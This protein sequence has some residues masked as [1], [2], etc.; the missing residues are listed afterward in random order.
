MSQPLTLP[1]TLPS[2]TTEQRFPNLPNIRE[3]HSLLVTLT[4]EHRFVLGDKNLIR[5]MEKRN[6]G[7]PARVASMNSGTGQSSVSTEP[8]Y[9]P[10]IR[11]VVSSIETVTMTSDGLQRKLLASELRD[12]SFAPLS[13]TPSLFLDERFD[14]SNP[15]YYPNIPHS[16]SELEQPSTDPRHRYQ[17]YNKIQRKESTEALRKE[18]ERTSNGPKD[19]PSKRSERRKEVKF[20]GKRD[21]RAVIQ[22]KLRGLN[23][24]LGFFLRKRAK[25]KL[26]IGA[27]PGIA[28]NF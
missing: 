19:S 27:E 3:R 15:T 12:R 4:R 22:T 26:P 16:L 23:R 13:M 1:G 20:E 18:E 24:K 14:L 25:E 21:A 17:R 7:S 9:Y 10:R 5:R 2:T 28:G 11:S 8:D 6:D